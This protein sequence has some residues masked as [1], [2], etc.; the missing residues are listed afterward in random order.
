[1][2]RIL[3]TTLVTCAL[4]LGAAGCGGGG[5]EAAEPE[6][7]PATTPA[8]VGSPAGAADGAAVF[9]GNCA[10]C[11]GSDGA[12]ASAPGIRGED[13]LAEIAAQVENGGGSMP[14]FSG[15]L[16]AAEI[17]AVAGYV[18]TELK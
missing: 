2:R 10:G 12:G 9:A 1:M 16:T 4:A 6:S 15:R 3:V 11:H 17:E 18:A 5:G 8:T 14:A 13:D 7:P